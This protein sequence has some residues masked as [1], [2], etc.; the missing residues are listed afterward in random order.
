[1]AF[2]TVLEENGALCAC[3]A[4]KNPAVSFCRECWETHLGSD[5]CFCGNPKTRGY[6]R[7]FECLGFED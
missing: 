7:C 4:Y 3:G 1:M 2:L 5:E 6:A